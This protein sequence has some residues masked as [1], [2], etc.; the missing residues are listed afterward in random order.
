MTAPD[1]LSQTS[2]P[3]VHSPVYHTA[4]GTPYL[5]APGVALLAQ[6]RVD[7]Q[8][9]AGFLD[10]YDPRLGFAGYLHDPAD[11]LPA[12]A[13]LT[14]TAGQVC[15]ASWGPRRTLNADASRYVRRLVSEGHESVLEHASY[16]LLLYGVSRSLTHELVRHRFLSVSQ[17]S[18]RYVSG[19][20]LRFVERP[21]FQRDPALHALFEARI[22][23]A[24]REHA[25]LTERLAALQAQGDEILSAERRTD[26]RKKIQQAA[27]ALLPNETET[28]LV[29]TANARA[30][31]WILRLRGS[32][33][34]ETEIRELA[35]RILLC[36]RAADPL[37]FGDL[38]T[39]RL[40]DGTR[41]VAPAP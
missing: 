19:A 39:V 36:L 20:A 32:P 10:G 40:D 7:L 35:A 31:R 8:G 13:L 25:E 22:D 6:P 15:Y 3:A 1:T 30:W 38:Q 14:K 23:R 4:A 28:V 33:H 2:P 29:A 27:R 16:S 11:A 26:L 34:A 24:A 18:Q 12:G 21:E 17:L 9:M 5:R 37:L 41:G